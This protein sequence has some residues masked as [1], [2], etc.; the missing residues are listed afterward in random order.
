MLTAQPVSCS[1][2]LGVPCGLAGASPRGSA[3][4]DHNP[5]GLAATARMTPAK[6]AARYSKDK[7]PAVARSTLQQAI[8]DSWSAHD[9]SSEQ[10]VIQRTVFHQASEGR[11]RLFADTT[12]E[13]CR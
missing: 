5:S 4:A 11:P 8:R 3:L 2:A 7:A 12:F 6:A 9:R 1:L 13:P 10:D